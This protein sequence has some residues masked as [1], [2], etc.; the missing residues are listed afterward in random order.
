MTKSKRFVLG[1]IHGRYDYLLQVLKKS[2]FDYENDLLIQVGDVVDRGPEPFKCMDELMKIKNRVF[3]IGNHDASF[4]TFVA[5][6]ID[7]LGDANGTAE[8]IAAWRKLD[9]EK[10]FDYL[11][12]FFREQKLYHVTEDNIIFVHGGFP[13]DEKLEEVSPNVFY[14]DRELISQAMS[15][16]GDQKLKT[17]YDFKEIY[18]GHTPTIYW[19]TIKPI[20]SGGVWNIDT[21]SGKGGPLTIMDIDT[22]EYWQSD[23]DESKMIK[24]GIIKKDT[25][26]EGEET[27]ETHS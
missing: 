22:H 4:L 15:C 8:T 3:L 14:W 26:P 6:N 23:F 1:D 12:T 13:R 10:Q 5:E 9:K 2:G 21:G 25:S 11:N 20:Y 7:F 18:V 19:D 16:K 24:Y 17:L 27:Q